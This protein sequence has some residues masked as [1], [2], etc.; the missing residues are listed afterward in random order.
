MK[1]SDQERLLNEILVDDELSAVRRASLESSLALLRKRR[2]SR[3]ALRRCTVAALPLLAA[4]VL[5]LHGKAHNPGRRMMAS[6]SVQQVALPPSREMD[7][8]RLI[9]DEE[10]FALF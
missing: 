10:L 4:L 6:N 9:S 5:L 7:N 3:S 1:Q 8:V 2:A